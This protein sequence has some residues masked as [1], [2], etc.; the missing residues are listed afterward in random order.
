MK[1]VDD[2]CFHLKK[3]VILESC[4]VLRMANV[5]ALWLE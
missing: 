4:R 5:E 3:V 2:S 1:T